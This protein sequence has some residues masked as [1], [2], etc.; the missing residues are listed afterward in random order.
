MTKLCKDCRWVDW[1]FPQQPHDASNALCR[2]PTSVMHYG[3][4][5][6]TGTVRPSQQLSCNVVRE[7]SIYDHCGPDGKHWEPATV[8][9]VE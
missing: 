5:K 1:F 9:G 6:V 7:W 3:P 8:G 2:H 4:D